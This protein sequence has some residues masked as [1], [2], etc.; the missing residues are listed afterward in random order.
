MNRT[1]VRPILV[2]AS[3]VWVGALFLAGFVASRQAVGVTAYAMSAAIYEIGGL[4]CHQLPER[5]FYFR[6]A[7]L[8]VCARCTGLYV[9]AAAAGLLAAGMRVSTQRWIWSRARALLITAALP[10]AVTLIYEWSSG[11]MPDHWIRAGAGLPLGAIVM[12]VVLAGVPSRS[13]VEIH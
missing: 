1:A 5:S 11:H 3:V 9:G 2:A 10:T 7:Q 13:R 6:G 4:I 8:P 12:L